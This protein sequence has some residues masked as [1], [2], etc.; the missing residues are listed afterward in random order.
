MVQHF[1]TIFSARIWWEWQGLATKKHATSIFGHGRACARKN[2]VVYLGAVFKGFRGSFKEASKSVHAIRSSSYGGS[3]SACFLYMTAK[4]RK[5][6]SSC[7]IKIL[8]KS[9]CFKGDSALFIPDIPADGT[10]AATHRGDSC[11]VPWDIWF[12]PS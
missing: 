1:K 11:S 6:Y 7:C 5:A 12:K 2:A 9:V 4:S 10:N 3:R 8:L